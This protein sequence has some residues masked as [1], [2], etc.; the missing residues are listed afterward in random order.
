MNM[1]T[2]HL[3]AL[4]DAER[5]RLEGLL[6]EFDQA[7][8]AERFAESTAKLPAE[9]GA[10]R[11]AALVE[12]VKIDMERRRKAGD[13]RTLESYLGEFPELGTAETVAPALIAAEFE[14]RRL[15][16]ET[17]DPAELSERFPQQ[18]EIAKQLGRFTR[19]QQGLQARCRS[20]PR[21]TRGLVPVGRPRH[22]RHRQHR[23]Q[24]QERNAHVPHV[25]TP[26]LGRPALRKRPNYISF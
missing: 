25:D 17:V 1:A 10:L 23:Q 20:G 3:L 21:L 24:R 13:P 12:M 16:G 6:F 7:W 18:A 8:S 26:F 19:R 2:D 11:M 14:I 9:N 5:E 22:D 15:A 4:S